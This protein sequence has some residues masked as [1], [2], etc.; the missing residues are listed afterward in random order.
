[1]FMLKY[2]LYTEVI[3]HD[4]YKHSISTNSYIFNSVAHNLS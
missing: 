3:V 1:M 2:T 4:I